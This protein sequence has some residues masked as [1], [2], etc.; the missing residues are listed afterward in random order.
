MFDILLFWFLR[1]FQLKSCEG[2]VCVLFYSLRTLLL[3]HAMVRHQRRKTIR[4]DSSDRIPSSFGCKIQG[5]NLFSSSLTGGVV[6]S[7]SIHP[8][9]TGFGDHVN[10]M[11]DLYN[12]F[13]FHQIEFTFWPPAIASSMAVC[14][15]PVV[16]DA[17]VVA[18]S[19]P[20]MQKYA[21]HS[22]VVTAKPMKMYLGP[23]DFSKCTRKWFSCLDASSATQTTADRLQGRCY[24]WAAVD[25]TINIQV[26]Y[27]VTF[28]APNAYLIEAS[29]STLEPNP[30]T[31]IGP[32]VQVE[33]K[34]SGQDYSAEETKSV[35]SIEL[36]L[37][38]VGPKVGKLPPPKFGQ[39]KGLKPVNP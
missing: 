23:R 25:T 24:I 8:G 35:R 28:Q 37:D 19:M 13:R 16:I 21:F 36:F 33:R 18:A 14:Y 3:S 9:N 38:Q 26:T 29:G 1:I 2:V 31:P 17:G 10:Y 15:S 11:D 34:D 32:P 20:Q 6:T 22:S 12:E 4:S 39:K 7:F 30:E 27:N 5:T